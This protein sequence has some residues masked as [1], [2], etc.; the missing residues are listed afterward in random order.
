MGLHRQL[1]QQLVDSLLV[2]ANTPLPDWMAYC[3]RASENLRLGL[4][5]APVRRGGTQAMVK[6]PYRGVASGGEVVY[7][8]R[9]KTRS[10]TPLPSVGVFE[11][12]HQKN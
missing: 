12:R 4:A 8:P 6:P 11:L 9:T 3:Y 2:I 10:Q 1:H 7:R 5:L